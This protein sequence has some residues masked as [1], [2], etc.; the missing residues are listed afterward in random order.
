MSLCQFCLKSDAK[1]S[2]PRCNHPYCGVDCYRGLSH[3]QC[4]EAFYK[5]CVQSELSFESS[6]VNR[7]RERTNEILQRAKTAAE[8]DDLLLDSDDEEDLSERITNIDLENSEKLWEV[9]TPEERQDFKRKLNSGELCKLV[10]PEE[11]N[12]GSVWWE[13][14][15][16]QRKIKDI[17]TEDSEGSNSLHSCLPPLI[18]VSTKIDTGSS[19][20]LVKCNLINVF[21]AYALTY[22][23]LSWDTTT[24]RET[25]SEEMHDFFASVLNMSTNLLND[26]NFASAEMAIA[27]G[28]VK[29]NQIPN[30]NPDLV[31]VA[32]SDVADIVKGPGGGDEHD[33]SL[34][35]LAALSDLKVIVTHVRDKYMKN[36]NFSRKRCV[37]VIKK[38]DY[39]MCWMRQHAVNF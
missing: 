18:E 23:H 20:P 38:I 6:D 34:Y 35:M 9:L 3:S 11:R 36:E 25:S 7:V 32:R 21:F 27:S 13:L 39:F 1:Y 12:E 30:L 33:D 28:A 17:S 10:P 5:D 2:C 16:P 26:E 8:S 4:S 29:A 31:K 24:S 22:R 14:R 15:L 37:L 19:S